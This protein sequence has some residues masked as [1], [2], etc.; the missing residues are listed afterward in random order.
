MVALFRT[1]LQGFHFTCR[2]GGDQREGLLS[3]ARGPV[4]QF[5]RSAECLGAET[6]DTFNESLHGDY[7]L[8]QKRL[9]LI[10]LT[11]ARR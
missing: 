4:E 10:V 1:E 6:M 2:G 5:A 11:G 9:S 7:G 3:V 8:W